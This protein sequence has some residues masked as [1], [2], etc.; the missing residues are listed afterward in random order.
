MSERVRETYYHRIHEFSFAH[1]Q[2]MGTMEFI[3]V[4]KAGN[5]G[6]NSNC[7]F[8]VALFI[9]KNVVTSNEMTFAK[10]LSLHFIRPALGMLIQK[11]MNAHRL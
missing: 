7:L 6:V 8:N 9:F 1:S 5:N 3:G 11:L 10:Q 4:R 2:G